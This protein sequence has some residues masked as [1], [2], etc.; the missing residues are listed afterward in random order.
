MSLGLL[1]GNL[2]AARVAGW[3]PA[4][5]LAALL[6]AGCATPPPAD[7][8]AARAAYEEANDPLEPLNRTIFEINRGLDKLIIRPVAELYRFTLPEGVRDGVRNAVNN[9]DTPNIFVHDMLQGEWQRGSE[10]AR[11]FTV[12]SVA[13][14][15]GVVDL[16]AMNPDGETQPVEFHS[17]D[18]GQTLAVWGVGEG[19]YLVLPLFGPSNVRDAVGR[20]GDLF[21]DPLTYVIP[22]DVRTEFGISRRLAGGID[23]RSRVLDTLDDIERESIDYYAAIRS[24]YRQ[25]RRNE[26]ANGR[27]QEIPAPDISFEYDDDLSRERRAAVVR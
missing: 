24:L 13:G 7:D 5:G 20:V 26:I 4:V 8:E 6:A 9:L 14:A 23:T 2:R 17:E 16:M 21:L 15:G 18:L 1:L 10:S 3:A 25:H 12:N 19:P 27:T 11:R 22:S